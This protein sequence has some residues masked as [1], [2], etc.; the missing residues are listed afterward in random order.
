MGEQTEAV[1]V[2]PARPDDREAVLAFGQE[3]WGGIDY[4]ADVWEDWLTAESGALLVAAIEEQPVGLVHLAMP[5]HED[6][7]LECLRVNPSMRRHGI[8]RVLTSQALVVAREQGAKVARLF[9]SS[10]NLA[11]QELVMR[12]FGFQKVAEVGRYTGRALESGSDPDADALLETEASVPGS[13]Q[14]PAADPPSLGPRLLLA[15]A[16]DYTRLRD[17][18]KQSNLAPANG[19]LQFGGW[20]AWTLR[21]AD[22]QDYLANGEAWLLEEWDVIQSVALV[23]DAGREMSPLATLQVRYIDGTAGGISALALVLREIA[24][25]RELEQIELWLPDLLI[26]QDAMNG[27]GYSRSSHEKMWVYQRSL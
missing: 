18:L 4:I 8:G 22:L 15:G 21:D 23:R 10:E 16:E 3:T 19:G 11:A 12:R 1:I 20:R 7:W 14:E 13:H 6:A 26:L 17:W 24:Q 9:T 5:S 2:R 27:A 25:E